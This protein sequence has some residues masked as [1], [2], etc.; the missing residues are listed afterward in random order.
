L[1]IQ[2]FCR[3]GKKRKWIAFLIASNFVIHP[4][5]LMS[6]VSVLTVNKIFRVTVLL[7]IYFLQRATMLALQAL[8]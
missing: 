6:T 3:R 8:Y 7:L 2:I 5:I 1:K 4:E